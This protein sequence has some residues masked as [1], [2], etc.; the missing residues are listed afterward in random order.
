M[1]RKR[2]NRYTTE[3]KEEAVKL[4]QEGDKNVNETA[5]GLGV[6]AMTLRNWIDKTEGKQAPKIE[7]KAESTAEENQRLRRENKRLR[8]ERE[9][10]KKATAFFAKEND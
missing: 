10:L 3:F 5:E 8:M 2:Y 1:G 6:S 4:A 9:I 7:K